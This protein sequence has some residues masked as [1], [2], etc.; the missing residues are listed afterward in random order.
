MESKVGIGTS[1]PDYTLDV[2]GTIKASSELIVGSTNVGSALSTKAPIASPTFTGT[3]DIYNPVNIPSTFTSGVNNLDKFSLVFSPTSGGE[4]DSTSV[5]F[6][7]GIAW[8][9]QQNQGAKMG[10][11]QSSAHDSLELWAT[12]GRRIS[13]CGDST[14]SQT[15]WSL[16]TLTC[17]NGKVGIGTTSPGAKL[18]IYGDA[19]ETNDNKILLKVTDPIASNDWVGIGLGG[20]NS[21]VKSGLIHQRKNT[22]GVGTLHFCTNNTLSTSD[23]TVSDS[24]MVIDSV[25][26]VGIGTDSPD[27]KLQVNGNIKIKHTAIQNDASNYDNGITF[28]HSGGVHNYYMGYQSGG[29]FTIGQYHPTAPTIYN[30]FF[31]GS[32]ST[33]LLNPDND[34]TL[35]GIGT[36]DPRTKLHIGDIANF[37]EGYMHTTSSGQLFW[38]TNA[39]LIIHPTPTSNTALNDPKPVLYLSRKGTSA[40]SY[41]AVATFSISRYENNST[42]SRTRLDIKLDDDIPGQYQPT[43][44]MTLLANGNVGIGT[45]SPLSHA[46]LHVNGTLFLGAGT[47]LLDGTLGGCIDFESRDSGAY[48]SSNY[49]SALIGTRTHN[50]STVVTNVN[51]GADDKMEMVFFIGNNPTSSYGPD[52][53]SFIGGEF[54]IHT[55]SATYTPS[56]VKGWDALD[57]MGNI[58]QNSTPAFI[59]DGGNVGIGTSSPD[60]KLQIN[61]PNT[62]AQSGSYES[63]CVI[64]G[65]DS[66]EILTVTHPN[67]SQG[68]QIGWDTIKKFGSSDFHFGVL[69]GNAMTIMSDGGLLCKG[70]GTTNYPLKVSTYKGWGG[71]SKKYFDYGRTNWTT[72]SS[73]FNL[74]VD[75]SHY[76]WA[77]GYTTSSDERIKKNIRDLSDS[78][79]LIKLRDISCVHYEYKDEIKNG[80]KPTIGFIAQQVASIYPGAVSLVPQYIPNEYRILTDISWNEVTT[81]D[82]SGN[83]KT[84]YYLTSESMGDV[85]GCKYRFEC[86]DLSANL[87]E[88]EIELKGDEYNRFEFK[89]KYPE[90]FLYGKEVDDFHILDKPRLFAINFSATQEIDK[91]QQYE[92]TKLEEQ[93]TKLTTAE[94][95]IV[96]LKNKTTSLE[97]TVADLISRITA[98]E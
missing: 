70:S 15:P 54:R 14:N 71:S 66:A 91:I 13:L 57:E 34:N 52:R 7:N 16:P 25:G 31:R 6:R 36:N 79:S 58:Y 60:W 44:V 42:Y 11:T 90:I 2:V 43:N 29:W 62:N 75:I 50:Y 93:T 18:H 73:S 37:Q 17:W 45:D 81:T 61:E 83:T 3:L 68:I 48:G 46:K 77:K 92:K 69:A 74:G 21:T 86:R 23:I 95:E 82:N 51:N 20:F 94:A 98:L 63:S 4:T 5:S 65:D 47:G 28:E 84:K 24:R 40:Q 78:E 56:E 12:N 19:E 89:Y 1:D 59:V 27:A 22:Y 35:V 97:T 49:S 76:C 64:Y 55:P 53:F 87:N 9:N 85:S 26:N 39:M 38:D 30:E 96:T 67:Q 32:G 8:T 72:T 10:I 41:G 88:E 80:G 33:I